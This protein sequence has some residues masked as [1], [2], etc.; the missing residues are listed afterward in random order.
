[1]L[2]ADNTKI[3]NSY[4]KAARG[5][6]WAEGYMLNV[7]GL[8]K[9]RKNMFS[10][11]RGRVLEV[12]AGT[13]LG[14]SVMP[15]DTHLIALD[16]TRPMLD[17]AQPR[18]KKYGVKLVQG[19]VLALPFAENSFDGVID[20]LCLC[21]YP[22]PLKALQEMARV[23][24]PEGRIVLIEHGLARPKWL[25]KFQHKH[26]EKHFQDLCCRWDMNMDD[27]IAQSGLT[28]ITS[29][30]TFFG[31]IYTYTLKKNP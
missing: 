14:F 1:M 27:L 13:G 24:K 6:D 8:K 11:L 17:I 12:G 9:L 25:Q 21:T 18:A 10:Q 2:K 31:A 28:I 23:L 15:K 4:S 16:L 3:Q 22:N 19:D 26:A 29:R 5:F 30:R 7:F 20:T